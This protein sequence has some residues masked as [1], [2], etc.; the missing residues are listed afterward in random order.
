MNMLPT[1]AAA[2]SERNY[3]TDR[4]PQPNNLRLQLK[5]SG[6][7]P[8]NPQPRNGMGSGR[9]PSQRVMSRPHPS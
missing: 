8:A 4:K 5:Q 3:L 6:R 2:N 1:R 9:D 7:R